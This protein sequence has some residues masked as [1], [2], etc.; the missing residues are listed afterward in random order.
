MTIVY[1]LLA[2]W[3]A[4]ALTLP[5][6]HLFDYDLNSRNQTGA[7]ANPSPAAFLNTS[8]LQLFHL[9]CIFNLSLST[10]SF[11][12]NDKYH[13][14]SPILKKQITLNPTPSS[15]YSSFFLLLSRAKLFYF[16]TS[17]S[18]FNSPHL[19]ICSHFSSVFVK[20]SNWH[21]CCQIHC[22]FLSLS[23]ADSQQLST[24]TIIPSFLKS[25]RLL[26]SLIPPS[27]F[28]LHFMAIPC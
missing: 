23:Y 16:L 15:S 6:L 27:L 28:T 17:I 7:Q 20:A 8:F 24:Q 14:V 25:V 26:A 2:P 4:T 3:C 12:S 9:F 22:T 18:L 1:H 13:I 10:R 21:P 5:F 11:S 19:G